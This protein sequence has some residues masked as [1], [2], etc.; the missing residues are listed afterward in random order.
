[1]NYA[2]SLI[3]PSKREDNKMEMA[4]LKK[5]FNKKK[6]TPPPKGEGNIMIERTPPNRYQY[7]F[8]GYLY[9]CNNFGHKPVHCKSYRNCKPRNILRYNNNKNVVEKRNYNSLSPLQ[10]YNF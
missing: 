10:E 7:I 6:S 8:L 2:N 4:P 3:N 9:S 5:I 1:M